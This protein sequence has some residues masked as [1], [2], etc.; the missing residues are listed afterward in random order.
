LLRAE[1][2]IAFWGVS[3]LFVLTPGA[4]WAYAMSAG[5]RARS[6]LP[7]VAGM[8]FGHLFATITVAAGVGAIVASVPAAL[9][10]LTIVG[11]LYLLW[12]GIDLLRRP[13]MMPE[14]EP[15]APQT[16]ITQA[17]R[18]LGVS[19]LNP[20]VVLLF[21]ALLPQFT[22]P[23]GNWPIG[24]QMVV[25]G[26]VHV[27]TC[28]VVYLAVGFGARRFLQTRPTAGRLVTRLSGVAL[29]VVAVLLFAEQLA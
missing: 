12:L 14:E 20:K 15:S 1:F 27:V 13:V 24:L 25:L 7:A 5:I 11:A 16:W 17:A 28:A 4:D 9:K 26:L 10:L 21:L 6:P 22:D 18:G 3:A 23:A 29:L 2:V 19:G 8:L